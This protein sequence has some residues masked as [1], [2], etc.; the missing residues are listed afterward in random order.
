MFWFINQN[1]L[2]CLFFI[3]FLNKTIYSDK[4]IQNIFSA[5]FLF[6][7]LNIDF[8]SKCWT[9]TNKLLIIQNSALNNQHSDFRISN[10]NSKFSISNKQALDMEIA[11][12]TRIK[13]K[14]TMEMNVVNGKTQISCLTHGLMDSWQNWWERNMS[15]S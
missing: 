1:F 9:Q 7:M 2:G 10:H 6:W 15:R 8:C 14:E 12:I 11:T 5:Y 4:T 3:I 13:T